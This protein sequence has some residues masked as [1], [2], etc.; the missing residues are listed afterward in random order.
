MKEESPDGWLLIRL[1]VTGLWLPLRDAGEL[2]SA[3]ALTRP[4]VVGD[5]EA[6]WEPGAVVPA[7]P[8]RGMTWRGNPRPADGAV[9]RPDRD[10]A[11]VKLPARGQTPEQ[12]LAR[13][14]AVGRLVGTGRDVPGMTTQTMR[15]STGSRMGLHLDN[16][17]QLPAEARPTS[18]NRASLNLGPEPRWF[19]FVDHDVVARY[20]P[21]QVPDTDTARRTLPLA[22]HPPAVVRLRVPVGWAYVA[23]TENLL[24][25]AS[26]LGQRSGTSHV[27]ALGRFSP[28]DGASDPAVIGIDA[29]LPAGPEPP[30]A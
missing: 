10:V 6:A 28:T 4:R 21:D 29:E 2:A 8:W 30:T 7:G 1:A 16:W 14:G 11:L 18:R 3:V 19:L 13:L 26:S 15:G 12:R 20:R 9:F 23:P 24:H 5:A 25:D 17:D 27:S 22:A